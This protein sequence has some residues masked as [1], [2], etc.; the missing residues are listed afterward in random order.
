MP[1]VAQF[2][3]DPGRDHLV[4][5]Q[6]HASACCRRCQRSRVERISVPELTAGHMPDQVY[7]TGDP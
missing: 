2:A 3:G 6:P 1:P 4:Q 7:E 5:Q